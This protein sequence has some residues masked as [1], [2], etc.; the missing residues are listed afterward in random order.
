MTRER[1]AYRCEECGREEARWVGRCAGCGAWNRYVE[2]RA[3]SAARAVRLAHVPEHAGKRLGTG[4]PELDRVLGGGLVAGSLVLL[5]GDPGIGKSTLL[6][7]AAAGAAAGGNVLYATAEESAEQTRLRAARLGVAAS[8]LFLIAEASLEAILGAA[9]ELKPRLLVVDSVQTVEVAGLESAP[10]SLLQVREAA[11]RL[12][13]FARRTATPTVLVGHVTKD[14]ALA[15]PK[16]LEHLVD[17]VLSFEG[18]RGYP[19]RVLRAVKNRFGS[20]Q[21]IGVFEMTGEGLREVLNPS[22]LFL[23]ERPVAVPGSCVVACMEGS[24]PL[25]VEIQAILGPSAGAPRRTATGFD[26]ARASLLL[27]VL[28][29][30]AGLAVAGLDAFVNVAGGI[31]VEERAADLGVVAAAASSHLGRAID[32]GTVVFGEVGLAGEVRSVGRVEERLAEAGRLGF[33]RCVLPRSAGER[34]GPLDLVGV[35]TVTEALEALG[36]T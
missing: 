8:D 18:E 22:A 20:T 30:R 7:A 31:R 35:R 25:L 12:Q 5:G 23:S 24:R 34:R 14:G 16:A 17:A 32:P 10:G 33:S 9:Q 3:G 2:S 28:D 26:P 29:R 1:T 21:E 6:L 4:I 27:A 19:Y 36:I 13:S 11:L 15:G